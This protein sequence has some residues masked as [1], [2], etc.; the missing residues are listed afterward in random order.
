MSNL[1]QLNSDLDAAKALVAQLEEAI[2]EAENEDA[3]YP[4]GTIFSISDGGYVVRVGSVHR[5]VAGDKSATT[6]AAWVVFWISDFS[7]STQPTLADVRK[8]YGDM[9]LIHNP[10]PQL[11]TFANGGVIIGPSTRVYTG[12]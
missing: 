1:N 11:A 6:E 5:D 10:E 8:H 7:G 9:T 4:E 12:W 3:Q 2:N